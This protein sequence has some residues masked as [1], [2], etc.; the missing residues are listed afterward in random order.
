MPFLKT[1]H[2]KRAVRESFEANFLSC[3]TVLKYTTEFP[4]QL[5][6]GE[7]GCPKPQVV[8]GKAKPVSLVQISLFDLVRS[9]DAP[10]CI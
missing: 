1:N 10:R 6:H 8:G 4:L 7:I 2:V 9:F 3:T 5:N